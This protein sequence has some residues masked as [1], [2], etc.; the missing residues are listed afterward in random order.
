V[1]VLV[2]GGAGFIGRVL[3]EELRAAGRAVRSASRGPHPELESL[4]V[5]VL[6]ADLTDRAAVM[7]AVDGCE[8]V[9]HVASLTG[10]WGPRAEFERVNVVGTQNVVAACLARGVRRLVY[11]S[12]PSV[13]FDG[14]DQRSAGN[15]LPYASRFLCAYA[16][17]KARA[18][19][20]VLAANARHGLATCALRPHLVFGPR[21]PHLLPR[22]M[23]RARAGRLF[24]VGDGQNEVGLTHV[25]NAAGA[26][27]DAERGL[28]PAA[29]HAG[30]AY[31]IA[32]SEPVRLWE[33][34]ATVLEGTGCPAPR[35]R[36]PARLAYA[37]GGALEL[38]WRALR[39]GGEPPLTRFVAAQLSSSHSYDLGPARRDFGY[40][41]RVDLR[42][43][44]ERL[45][46][47][48]REPGRPD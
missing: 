33:W 7:R 16:E 18:E 45:I 43:A 9:F 47:S 42:Q 40:R 12:S 3:V 30:K 15:D 39:L 1:K 26:H 41:E 4:G 48:L 37:A 20:I 27:V 46:R 35:A 32:Q 36:L 14:L 19:R 5:E 34:I 11:T 25:E 38:A 22:L 28:S 21:D 13:C 31:F 44:T 8:A 24:V 29:P 6:Q 10:V 23:A 17:T 2:T